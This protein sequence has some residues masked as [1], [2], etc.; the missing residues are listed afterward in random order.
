MNP[1]T[2][3]QMTLTEKEDVSKNK[4]ILS[5]KQNKDAMTELKRSEMSLSR[6]SNHENETIR[7]HEK[8]LQILEESEKVRKE[9]ARKKQEE[10]QEMQPLK[11]YHC[12]EE[13]HFK[14]DCPN[15]YQWIRRPIPK[16]RRGHPQYINS[17]G[18]NNFIRSYPN[19]QERPYEEQKKSYHYERDNGFP[20][21]S[22]YYQSQAMSE[23]ERDIEDSRSHDQNKRENER[24]NINPLNN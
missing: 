22:R 9:E 8:R 24:V 14:R 20:Q 6:K 16:P 21:A 17:Y 12:L 4:K 15:R 11:C 2:I 10:K 5:H 19:Y 7:K 23:N 3:K 1:P 13:G 18:A